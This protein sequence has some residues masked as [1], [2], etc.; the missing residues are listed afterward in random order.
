MGGS[1][2]TAC[3]VAAL[4]ALPLVAAGMAG[5]A[6]AA[7]GTS[8]PA[9]RT[10]LP[11]SKPAW[12]TPSAQAASPNAAPAAVS[13]RVYL[14][15]AGGEAALQAAVAA[16]STPGSPAYR[17]FITPAQYRAQFG[18]TQ[19][20]VDAVS[21]WLRSAGMTVDAVG[22]GTRFV[23]ASGPVS[24]LKAAFDVTL[25]SYRYRGGTYWAPTTDASVPSAV[26][27]D[28]IGALGLDNGPNMATPDLI[29]PDPAPSHG[30]AGPD[31][32][33]IPPPAGFANARPCSLSYGQLLATKQADGTTP[34][35]KFD[36]TYRDYA[37]CGYVPSQFQTAY[38]LTGSTATGTGTAV[39]I[40]DAYAS[41]T[42]AADANTYFGRH[43]VPTFASGQFVERLASSSTHILLCDAPNWF[44]EQSLDVEAVHGIA[45]GATVLYYGARSCLNNDLLDAEAQVVDDNV[46]SIVSNSWGDT[47][48]N[49][50][51]GYVAAEE[52][53]FQ[54]GALQGIGFQFSSGDNGDEL[55]S[56]GLVQADYPASDP[57]VVAVGGTT[58]AI[59][60]NG[61]LMWQ[62][63]WGTEKYTLSTD[64]TTWVPIASLPFLYGAGGGFSALFNRPAYQ[65]GVVPT[66]APPGRAVP[67]VAMDA[68]VTT[69]MLIGITQ[70]FPDGTRY[71]E[72]RIG[73]T[74][75]ASPL[76]AGIQ[77]L[78]TQNAGGRLGWT[79]P[80]IYELDRTKPQDFNDVLPLHT[81]DANVRPDYANNV[82]PTGGILYSIRTFNQDLGLTTAPGWDDVTG[83]GVPSSNY[84][85]AYTR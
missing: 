84:L 24:A 71:G 6:S 44:S 35:P 64:G 50:T 14:A 52:Q 26:A 58:T 8:T 68:D 23:E 13:V 9:A 85:S 4:L 73:G 20:E 32:V 19:S 60:T 12:A 69:G 77:A 29:G 79:T 3:S 11:R 47:E 83:V 7:S 70:R 38:G 66:S 2:A 18:P 45:P 76:F 49:A 30:P 74:S 17:H 33:P 51:G 59:G 55:L 46:A 54:Q 61:S 43:G 62:T 37:I 28:V 25:A 40:I 65:T 16:V 31:S 42:L 22:P 34:L 48:Q 57:L 75:L 80:A 36:G 63:G 81:G 78:A 10:V 1:R 67:D 82:D 53:V 15:P 5:P 21:A 72:Y 27:G 56:S 41:P 39:A